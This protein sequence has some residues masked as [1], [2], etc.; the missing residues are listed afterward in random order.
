MLIVNRKRFLNVVC[1]ELGNPVAVS[2]A[3]TGLDAEKIFLG[4]NDEITWQSL[5]D[6]EFTVEFKQG[7]G[8]PF[9]D[10]GDTKKK[11]NSVPGKVATGQ[12]GKKFRY[13]ILIEGKTPY[14]P[15]IIIE[16]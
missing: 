9:S 5:E 12:K 11:G 13:S 8:Q 6:Q 15:E 14:D 2:D 1:D 10:W 4:K 3:E 16:R 7:Y